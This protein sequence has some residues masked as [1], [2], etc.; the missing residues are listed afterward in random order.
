M[1]G[2]MIAV[3]PTMLTYECW[4]M[5]GV[6]GGPIIDLATGEVIGIHHSGRYEGGAKKLG[7]GVPVTAIETLLT[8]AV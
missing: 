7:F 8:M 6:A 1:P 2:V 4:T 3:D 5:A